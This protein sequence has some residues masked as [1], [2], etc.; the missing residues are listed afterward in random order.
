MRS[1]LGPLLPSHLRLGDSCLARL[2]LVREPDGAGHV[3]CGPA[4]WRV[5]QERGCR[6][7]SEFGLP[8]GWRNQTLAFDNVSRREDD[9]FDR[10][11]NDSERKSGL[12][13]A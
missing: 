2:G 8:P 13:N 6:E 11:R 3:G 7:A 10:G 5:Q 9:D 4:N 12:E 1:D